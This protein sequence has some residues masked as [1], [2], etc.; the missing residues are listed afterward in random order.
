MSR[1]PGRRRRRLSVTRILQVA[2]PLAMVLGAA[3]VAVQFIWLHSAPW[4]TPRK[5]YLEFERDVIDQKVR[6]ATVDGNIIRAEYDGS[7]LAV[8]ASPSIER[9]VDIMIKKG[10]EVEAARPVPASGLSLPVLL[11]ALMPYP[12]LAY[13]AMGLIHSVGTSADF[14]ETEVLVDSIEALAPG[15]ARIDVA[16]AP[17]IDL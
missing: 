5:S 16:D 12:V 11:L 1:D 13:F 4:G 14:A 2:L 7:L 17:G 9:S 8:V 3:F 10:V 6:K 15:R